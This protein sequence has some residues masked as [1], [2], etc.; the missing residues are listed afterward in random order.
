MA[1][2]D[3][4]GLKVTS[5]SKKDCESIVKVDTG[6][7]TMTVEKADKNELASAGGSSNVSTANTK[8]GSSSE[9]PSGIG[10]PT[11]PKN[12]TESI[13]VASPKKIE[14]KTPS[15]PSKSV[16]SHRTNSQ[17]GAPRNSP[18]KNPWNKNPAPQSST[19]ASSGSATPENKQSQ[20]SSKSVK[21]KVPPKK[22]SPGRGIPIPKVCGPWKICIH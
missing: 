20:P 1:D 8:V 17:P 7:L 16:L 22:D 11:H 21:E 15:P 10:S 2:V 3:S 5:I 19:S 12:A 18:R 9:A 4:E 6:K 13:G 14:P